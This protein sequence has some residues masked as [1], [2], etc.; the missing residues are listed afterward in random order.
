MNLKSAVVAI[1]I[2]SL[3]TGCS[4]KYALYESNYTFTAEN[5]VP[6]YRQLDYWAAHPYKRILRQCA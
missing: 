4:N 3:L 5:G 2:Y 6:D 1:T